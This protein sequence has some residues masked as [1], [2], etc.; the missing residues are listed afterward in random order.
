[1][2]LK[3]LARSGFDQRSNHWKAATRLL[4]FPEPSEFCLGYSVGSPLGS[5]SGRGLQQGM[6]D[7]AV[8]A[9]RLG[10][11]SVEHF[12][13]LAL[14]ESGIGA[15]RIGDIVCNVLKEQFID[16]TAD[17]ARRHDIPMEPINVVHTRWSHDYVRWE[18]DVVMLPRNPYTA[19]GVL[20][21]PQRFLRD[22]PTVDPLEFWDWAWTNENEDIRGEFNYDIA[23]GRPAGGGP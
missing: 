3:L 13:E 18:N 20:L 19:K 5:G 10:I 14:F 1:M 7:G 17:V 6:L 8:E 22:L 11:E 16:Y 4:V 2:A 21:T 23:S 15:D 12:E 9:I